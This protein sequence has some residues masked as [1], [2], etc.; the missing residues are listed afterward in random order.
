SVPIEIPRDDASRAGPRREGRGRQKRPR[1]NGRRRRDD[2]EPRRE[3]D[4][5][6]DEAPRGPLRRGLE[7]GRT[8]CGRAAFGGN[9]SLSLSRWKEE[10]PAARKGAARRGVY[11]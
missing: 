10:G 5:R 8:S 3:D 2:D 4:G 1:Q 11:S 9:I 7:H 6:S